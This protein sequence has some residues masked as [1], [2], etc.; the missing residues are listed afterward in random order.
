M[1][2]TDPPDDRPDRGDEDGPVTLEDLIALRDGDLSAEQA[3][4]VTSRL[5]SDPAAAALLDE[6]DQTDVLL[7]RLRTQPPPA[8][9]SQRLQSRIADEAAARAAGERPAGD[10]PAGAPE[11][12]REDDAGG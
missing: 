3:R 8:E 2:P 12:R 10:R 4:R 5:E 11:P 9:L 6:L 7:E 1:T